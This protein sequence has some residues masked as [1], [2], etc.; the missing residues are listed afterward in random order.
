MK[1][2]RKNTAESCEPQE[3]WKRLS[4]C[5][6]KEISI[7]F[8]S[9]PPNHSSPEHMHPSVQVLVVLKGSLKVTVHDEEELVSEGDTVYIAGN[10]P[11]IVA[12]P[13]NIESEGLDIFIPGRSFDFWKNKKMN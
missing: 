3:G 7:E 8:F 2:I 1:V 4:L 6:E 11:H 9:K 5:N 10:E 13:L 12:N